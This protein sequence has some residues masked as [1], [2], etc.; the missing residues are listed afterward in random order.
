MR[1][2][3][4]LF[5]AGILSLNAASAW[6]FDQ[7]TIVSPGSGYSTAPDPNNKLTDPDNRDSGKGV[8]P[9]GSDG[10]TLQFGV[11]RGPSSTFGWSNG[12]SNA[13]PDP[14]HMPFL[15]GN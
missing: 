11:Q 15:N 6:A 3:V 10:P 7:Q 9:F 8:R 4:R 1:L 2:A 5:A 13:T 14:Y 12:R